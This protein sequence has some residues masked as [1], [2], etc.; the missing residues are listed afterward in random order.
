LMFLR[1]QDCDFACEEVG[2]WE[3]YRLERA[4]G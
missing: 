4:V 1:F 2:S 3:D